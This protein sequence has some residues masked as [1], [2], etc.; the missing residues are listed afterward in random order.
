MVI[1]LLKVFY[2]VFIHT[3]SKGT[4]MV[5]ELVYGSRFLDMSE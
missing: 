2:A 5:I 1:A 4:K 3:Y